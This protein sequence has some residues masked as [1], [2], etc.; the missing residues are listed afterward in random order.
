[1]NMREVKKLRAGD[2]FRRPSTNGHDV[3]G[4]R[5][6]SVTGCDAVGIQIMDEH[7]YSTILRH[8]AMSTKDWMRAAEPVTAV[9]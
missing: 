7:G 6:Y 5:R 8:S 1:V 9:A 3:S 2:Q 4:F